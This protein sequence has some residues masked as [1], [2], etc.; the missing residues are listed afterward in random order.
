MNI[1][2][3]NKIDPRFKTYLIL[4]KEILFK[5]KVS[6][7]EFERLNELLKKLFLEA[8]SPIQIPRNQLELFQSSIK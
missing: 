7:K 4:E 6:K 8:T 2:L 1:A 5:N 3:N